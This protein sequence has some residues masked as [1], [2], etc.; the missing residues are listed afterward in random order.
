MSSIPGCTASPTFTGPTGKLLNGWRADEAV[1]PPHQ[2]RLGLRSD[3]RPRSRCPEHEPVWS[4]NSCG[5]PVVEFKQPSQALTRAD[6]TR[7]LADAVGWRWKQNHIRLAL[8]V[9]FVVKMVSVIGKHV[10]WS[11]NSCGLLSTRT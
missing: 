5:L 8:M 9:S 2:L 3:C 7:R 4:K 6:F 1:G 11:K 10:V